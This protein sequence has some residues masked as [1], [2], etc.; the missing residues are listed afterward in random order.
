MQKLFLSVKQI[1]E[2]VMDDACGM[3]G[4]E[5]NCIKNFGEET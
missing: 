4:R 5:E 3:H 1:K 2:N